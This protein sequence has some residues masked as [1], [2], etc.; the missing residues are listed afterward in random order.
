MVQPRN[1]FNAF[2]CQITPTVPVLPVMPLCRQNK[3]LSFNKVGAGHFMT[4]K[5]SSVRS[6]GNQNSND[7]S[8]SYTSNERRSPGKRGIKRLS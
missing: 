7:W 2:W 3:S 4:W 6:W 5:R 8:N 1:C